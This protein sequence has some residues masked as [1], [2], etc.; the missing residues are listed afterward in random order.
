MSGNKRAIRPP[1]MAKRTLRQAENFT[2]CSRRCVRKISAILLL[3]L[4]TPLCASAADHSREQVVKI[5]TQ[6]KRADYEGDRAALK[7]LYGDL[8]FFVENKDLAARVRYWRG[9]ALWRRAINGFNDHVDTETRPSRM[10]RSARCPARAFLHMPFTS[11]TR[12]VP[13]SLN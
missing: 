3:A 4:A 7:R 10:Q 1:W 8:T 5:V 13:D 9:F 12:G 2:R 11:K 6:I